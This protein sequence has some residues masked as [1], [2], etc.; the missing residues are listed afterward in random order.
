MVDRDELSAAMKEGL[1]AWMREQLA[2]LPSPW[3][4]L[5]G[6][7]RLLAGINASLTLGPVRRPDGFA[8]NDIT[9]A[10]AEG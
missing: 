7:D 6:R 5:Q 3:P 9:G 10:L 2:A 1:E 8:Q 4:W